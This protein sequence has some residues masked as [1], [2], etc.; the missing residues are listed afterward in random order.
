MRALWSDRQN[1]SHNVSQKVK[2]IRRLHGIMDETDQI[3]FIEWLDSLL[4]TNMSGYITQAQLRVLH[5]LVANCAPDLVPR[6]VGI[7]YSTSNTGCNGP[8]VGTDGPGR[9]TEGPFNRRKRLCIAAVP[10]TALLCRGSFKTVSWNRWPPLVAQTPHHLCRAT[11]SASPK[12]DP[13][14]PHPCNMP[15]AK[16]EVALQFSE[17]CA[18][19]TA[20]QHSLFCSAEVI[21]T[22]SCAAAN[23]KLH[24]NIEK[25][26]LQESGAFLP[27]S[28]G[29]QAPTF[30]HP[31]FGPAD[32]CRA[33]LC[34]VSRL[35][36][37]QCRTRIVL[38]LLKWQERSCLHSRRAKALWRYSPA[39]SLIPNPN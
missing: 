29:F 24:C 11:L 4:L 19:G 25:A 12:P 14:K 37:S 28:C 16:T 7:S 26:A 27:L 32:S 30:R 6:I 31:C 20:L 39:S 15:Q 33:K 18:A 5:K 34:R 2:R 13:S 36:F 22:K 17:C 38:H 8:I 21:W 1:C 23:E 9:G 35:T 3:H 10:L